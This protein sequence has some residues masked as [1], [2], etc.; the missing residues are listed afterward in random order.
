ME[1]FA[2]PLV[3]LIL[4]II[5]LFVFKKPVSRLIDRTEKVSKEGLQAH[6]MHEQQPEKP[7]S[8]VEESLKVYDNQIVLETERLIKTNL[9]NL[10]PRD[11]EERERFLLR[12]F[13]QALLTLSFEQTYYAIYG[14]QI[15][16]LSFLNNK[17][18]SPITIDDIRPFYDGA[19]K[20][21]P[22]FYKNISFE[23]WLG[24]MVVTALVQRNV[25]DV[26]ITMRGKE[27]LKFIIEQGYPPLKYN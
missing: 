12:N 15:A 22:D 5:I 17:R 19:L 10:H 26:S 3:G 13:A 11:A 25:N 27:F 7:A 24:Y 8:K 18:F 9:D 14:S 23:S 2:W 21:N 16:A 4:G 1:Q 6:G 20:S